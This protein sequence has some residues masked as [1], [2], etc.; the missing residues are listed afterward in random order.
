MPRTDGVC[1]LY[2][3]EI[4]SL[5]GEPES[6]KGW[7][8]LSTVAELIATG[9]DV[10]YLDFE[11]SATSIVGRLLALGVAAD[12][13]PRR[14]AYVRPT[15][16]FDTAA[17]ADLSRK[18]FALAVIDGVSEAY[19]LLGLD[20]HSSTD[21]AKFLAAIPRPLAD[22]GAAA[23]EIDHVVKDREHR[24]RYAF[25]AQHK[26]AGVAVAYGTVVVDEPSRLAPGLVKLTISKDRHGHV[27]GHALGKVIAEVQITPGD[28][29]ERVAVTIAP[30]VGED[31]DFRPTRLME[32]TSIAIEDHPGLGT[33][34]LR[35]AVKGK[36][37]AK[38]LALQRLVEEEYVEARRDGQKLRHYSLRPFREVSDA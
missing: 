15:D 3:G 26:L 16:P 35:A 38:R 28:D 27:R 10:L 32:R 1:L 24:G 37:D 31:G 30:G 7:I 18:S 19:A 12:A 13:I 6:C 29:G 17:F 11:D 8:A 5:A 2:P 14:L 20:V 4:H 34:D 21:A 23:L 9:R 22:G 36:D 33:R 25:G